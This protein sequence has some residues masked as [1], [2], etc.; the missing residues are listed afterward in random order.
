MAAGGVN[1]AAF[2]ACQRFVTHVTGTATM[3]GMDAG[4]RELAIDSSIVVGCFVVGAMTSV[5]AIEGRV[6][7]GRKPLHALP[8]IVVA[9]ILS[10]V[11]L[12]GVAG[13]FGDFGGSDAPPSFALVA[14]LSFALGLQNAAVATSTNQV[15]RTTHLTGPATDLGVHLA[16]ALVAEGARRETAF[17]HALLRLG[18]IIGFVAGAALIVPIAARFGFLAFLVPAAAV[19]CATTLSFVPS[20]ER[21]TR[22]S[23]TWPAKT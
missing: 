5:L 11:G 10:L 18:K 14:L 15:V 6:A 3:L 4:R 7:R 9:G 17:K 20:D 8:L 2:L 12:L 19:L 1:A 13:A 23:G 21:V 22:P 16:T